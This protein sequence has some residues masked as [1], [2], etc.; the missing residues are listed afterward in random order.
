MRYRTFNG[1]CNNLAYGYQG[2]ANT[3]IRRLLPA[4]YRDGMGAPFGSSAFRYR[5]AEEAWE[6][7]RG[8]GMHL[9]SDRQMMDPENYTVCETSYPNQLPEPRTISRVFHTTD[10]GTSETQ[11][12][13]LMQFGQFVTHDVTLTPEAD[14]ED[15]VDCCEV[16]IDSVYND[17]CLVMPV[18]PDD[19]FISNHGLDCLEFVRSSQ[20]CAETTEQREQFIAITHYLDLSTVYGSDDGRACRLRS[21][22]GGLLLSQ[23]VEGQEYL[24]CL[25]DSP[26][27]V[28]E[29]TVAEGETPLTSG[30]NRMLE[31]PTLAGIHTLFMREHNRIARIVG[32]HTEGLSNEEIF[33]ETRRIMIAQYQNIVYR[34]FLPAV[35]GRVPRRLQIRG[36]S[37]YEPER[38]A[39]ISNEFNTAFRFGH[40]MIQGM[41]ESRY[42]Q[43][44]NISIVTSGAN[45]VTYGIDHCQTQN[46]TSRIH[47][48]VQNLNSIY[49]RTVWSFFRE[50][51]TSCL[52]C[53]I[54]C[55]SR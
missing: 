50:V 19:Q 8:E 10:D 2:A 34:E 51:L 42:R 3:R 27:I 11:T 46:H 17:D 26:T 52:E 38:D 39:S 28:A 33:Q 22:E 20:F 4:R 5:V 12:L 30:D 47:I 25:D 18:S 14:L 7:R 45:C 23:Q 36:S 31:V 13:M 32:D 55:H 53:K 44:T 6:T 37:R 24:P 15:G 16:S 29:G 43:C 41:V 40:S 35:L 9:Y 48:G 49:L 54:L 1:F 21:D